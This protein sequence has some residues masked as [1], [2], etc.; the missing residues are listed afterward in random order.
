M[1][2]LK[3]QFLTIVVY[4]NQDSPK[5][6]RIR[7]SA[8]KFNLLFIPFIS[9]VFVVCGMLAFSFAKKVLFEQS[10]N[11]PAL[12]AKFRQEKE[13]L[14]NNILELEKNNKLILEKLK[15]KKVEATGFAN[16]FA[17]IRGQEDLTNEG[18][19]SVEDFR[20]KLKRQGEISV[21][22]NMANPGLKNN[23]ISGHVILVL[24]NAE[25]L[26]FFPKHLSPE[27]ESFYPFHAGETFTFSNLRPVTA[28]FQIED[29]ESASLDL[30]IFS[31]SGDL[32]YKSHMPELNIIN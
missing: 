2:S 22:F 15:N 20:V 17:P 10:E 19:V 12:V 23:R 3:E 29:L 5:C 8:I 14:E 30:Y 31:R 13:Q 32:Y 18:I 11:E 27:E 28:S 4:R 21:H 25:G 7:N 24:R 26:R 16:F 6:F 9:F 1:S